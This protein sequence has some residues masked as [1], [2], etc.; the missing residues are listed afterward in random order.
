MSSHTLKDK[1]AFLVSPEQFQNEFLNVSITYGYISHL[2]GI[3]VSRLHIQIDCVWI[4]STWIE[5]ENSISEMAVIT[6][7]LNINVT[8]ALHWSCFT[9][10]YQ[11]SQAWKYIEGWKVCI[12]PTSHS[13]VHRVMLLCAGGLN[14]YSMS[15][16]MRT[17]SKR[18][19][20]FLTVW[21][22]FFFFLTHFIA[23]LKDALI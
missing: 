5:R 8:A 2:I 14:K 23:F 21:T 15:Y 19:F 9:T 22:G 10:L 12:C 6:E 3:T 18:K 7:W 20:R 16:W 11:T 17:L 1:G 4:G 13:W